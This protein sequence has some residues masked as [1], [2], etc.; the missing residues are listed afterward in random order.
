MLIQ[1]G[2]QKHFVQDRAAIVE[3][4]GHWKLKKKLAKN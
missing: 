3:G 2:V 1:S 4:R